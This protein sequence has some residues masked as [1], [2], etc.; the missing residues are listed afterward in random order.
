LQQSRQGETLLDTWGTNSADETAFASGE[1]RIAGQGE[2]LL[3]TWGTNSVLNE[4]VAA[5]GGIF[6]APRLGT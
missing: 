3:G 4:V 1:G 5:A 6:F 2:T